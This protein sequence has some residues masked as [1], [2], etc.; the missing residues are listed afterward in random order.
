M[1]KCRKLTSRHGGPSSHKGPHVHEDVLW[2]QECNG[3]VRCGFGA[4]PGRDKH[5]ER[6][7]YRMVHDAARRIQGLSRHLCE[8]VAGSESAAG[9]MVVGGMVM[10]T[11]S[12]PSTPLQPGTS[13]PGEVSLSLTPLLRSWPLAVPM[14]QQRACPG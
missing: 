2:L 11:L 9:V 14:H 13:V 3:D 6:S 5:N 10:D 12:V 7:A 1:H 4:R 8:S